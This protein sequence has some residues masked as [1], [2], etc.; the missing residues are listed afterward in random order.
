MPGKRYCASMLASRHVAPIM[1][2]DLKQ[3]EGTTQFMVTEY[4]VIKLIIVIQT[5]R[6]ASST[7]ILNL[8]QVEKNSRVPQR[9]AFLGTGNTCKIC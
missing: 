8:T 4:S 6:H 5:H 3:D 1:N 9:T 7:L 2:T